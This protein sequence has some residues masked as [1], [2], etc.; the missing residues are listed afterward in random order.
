LQ[1]YISRYYQENELNLMSR[2]FAKLREVVLTY[3]VPLKSKGFFNQ[4]TVSLV[5]RNLL[6][7]AEKKDIDLDRYINR[8]GSSD[9][10]TPTTKR[11]GVN[12]NFTF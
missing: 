6:Y 9:F 5:A 11:Y 12:F 10:D 4:M 7:F 8:Q 2:S 1:D 3:N